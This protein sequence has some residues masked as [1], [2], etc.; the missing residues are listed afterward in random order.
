MLSVDR[1]IEHDFNEL[2]TQTAELRLRVAHPEYRCAPFKYY[3]EIEDSTTDVSMDTKKDETPM[4][5]TH[6]ATTI[7]P[8]TRPNWHS[9]PAITMAHPESMTFLHPLSPIKLPRPQH[10]PNISAQDIAFRPFPH[11]IRGELLQVL[12]MG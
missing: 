11:T 12:D 1:R 7:L 10:H 2:L 5:Q 4:D 3:Q 9:D 6:Y 8:H